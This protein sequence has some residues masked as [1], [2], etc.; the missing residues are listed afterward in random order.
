MA[1]QRVLDTLC[2]TLK[3]MWSVISAFIHLCYLH[4]DWYF[5]WWRQTVN[6]CLIWTT[7][8][9]C[10]LFVCFFTHW[11]YGRIIIYQFNFNI[12][13]CFCSLQCFTTTLHHTQQCFR[14]CLYC[15]SF[16]KQYMFNKYRLFY[17]LFLF[18]IDS[19][20][21]SSVLMQTYRRHDCHTVCT[22]EAWRWKDIALAFPREHKTKKQN[23][24][25]VHS[26][27]SLS[28]VLTQGYRFDQNSTEVIL[29]E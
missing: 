15:S 7:G 18:C 29:T 9:P 5:V 10:F 3:N 19:S 21:V 27:I 14:P 25:H 23:G 11:K 24:L 2:F 13:G 8:W 6:C 12:Y 17:T 28:W 26:Q 4:W 16:N 20:R 1:S 22:G